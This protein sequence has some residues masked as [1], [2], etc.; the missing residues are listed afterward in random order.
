M[1][2]I[3]NTKSNYRNLNGKELLVKEIV[4]RRV[5]CKVQ[6]SEFPKALCIDFMMHEVELLPDDLIVEQVKRE[7]LVPHTPEKR[8]IQMFKYEG[9]NW[10]FGLPVKRM[11]L[12]TIQQVKK[13]ISEAIKD[14]SHKKHEVEFKIAEIVN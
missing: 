11:Y 1:K 10:C 4:G 9:S 8:Y 6:D 13:Q 5:T 7:G 14:A 3:P 12:D 2:A